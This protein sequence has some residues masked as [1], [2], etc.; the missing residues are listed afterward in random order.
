MDIMK[1]HE[2]YMIDETGKIYSN[3]T[4]QFLKGSLSDRGYRRMHLDGRIFFLH[5][6][7]AIQYLNFDENN[8]ENLSIDHIDMN[9]ENNHISNLRIVS[10][11]TQQIN[12]PNRKVMVC[13]H[14]HTHECY[15]FDNA[16]LLSKIIGSVRESIRDCVMNRAIQI[17]GYFFEPYE[18]EIQGINFCIKIND[19]E[20]NFQKYDNESNK[21]INSLKPILCQ[22]ITTNE[23]Y[24]FY[25]K[26]KFC[27]EFNLT[28]KLVSDCLNGVQKKHKGF[29]FKYISFKNKA[30]SETIPLGVESSDSKNGI[31][32]SGIN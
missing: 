8:K 30:S 12:M 6:L 9:K 24:L 28:P 23:I 7:L 13:F 21:K 2:D 29:R 16:E 20:I 25:D 4:K 22:N 27:K 19:Y 18:K 1:N 31:S 32:F 3:K 5:R 17:N 11:S 14:I 26:P 10:P 15:V